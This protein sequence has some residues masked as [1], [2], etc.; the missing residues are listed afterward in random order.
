MGS[1]PFTSTRELVRIKFGKGL[2][3]GSEIWMILAPVTGSFA[4][5]NE[6]VMEI[7]L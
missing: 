6:T 5:A 3:A 7:D 1:S 4:E 2:A